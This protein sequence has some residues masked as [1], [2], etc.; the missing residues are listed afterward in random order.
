MKLA[1]VLSVLGLSLAGRLPAAET[2][3][4]P[5]PLPAVTHPVDNPATP[6]KIALGK[7]LFFDPRLSRTERVACATCHDPARGFASGERLARGV[8][9]R[10]GRRHVPSL[11][12]VAYQRAFFWDGRALTLEEQAL[13]PI[14][15]PNEMDMPLDRL[16]QKLEE[17]AD[18]RQRF[19]DVFGGP[20]TAARIAQ[21]LAAYERTILSNDTPSTATCGASGR[22]SRP[23]RSGG[24]GYSS[25]RHA[26]SSVTRG[27]TSATTTFTTSASS[28]A[29]HPTPAAGR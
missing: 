25:A 18:Y 2:L 27:R 5:P 22:R 23:G 29:R 20:P 14:Q 13:A 16:V 26:A 6:Q 24:C 10:P 17:I 7:A 3:P 9:G 15:S 12:N 11:V 8:D 1:G 28:T 4:L 19:Q 21:A